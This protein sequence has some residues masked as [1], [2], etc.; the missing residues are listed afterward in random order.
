M[1]ID[2]TDTIKGIS[3]IRLPENNHGVGNNS[4]AGPPEAILPAGSGTQVK[5]SAAQFKLM[6]PGRQDI[7]TA[8]VNELKMACRNGSLKTDGRKIANILIQLTIDD[9]SGN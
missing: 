1:S 6:Q 8:R 7:D 3:S 4:K 2:K 5:L 9:I